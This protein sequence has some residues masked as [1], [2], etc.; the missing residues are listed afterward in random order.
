MANGL[1][2]E[3]KVT[4]VLIAQRGKKQQNSP[5]WQSLE[6]IAASLTSLL[7]RREEAGFP[8][9]P[10]QWMARKGALL[11]YQPALQGCGCLPRAL[12]LL[13]ATK[14]LAALPQLLPAGP[15]QQH[16]GARLCSGAA[17]GHAA[18]H[19]FPLLR[20]PGLPAVQGS[21]T[22]WQRARP[23]PFLLEPYQNWGWFQLHPPQQLSYKV[24]ALLQ[25]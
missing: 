14:W 7:H 16:T 17:R 9:H 13:V 10:D 12:L 25:L 3:R 2:S 1:C 19:V 4:A 21:S 23:R 8:S 24:G 5:P 11:N 20:A 6:G 15:C 18:T 22:G